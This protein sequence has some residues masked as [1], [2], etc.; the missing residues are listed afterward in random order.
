MTV[1]LFLFYY[2]ITNLIY[3]FTCSVT[4]EGTV[5]LQN[6]GNHANE[7][8]SLY[9]VMSNVITPQNAY[10]VHASRTFT[11]FITQCLINNY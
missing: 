6:I 4:T 8:N 11:A 10:S 2:N 9:H 1:L 7:S 5:V 3:C